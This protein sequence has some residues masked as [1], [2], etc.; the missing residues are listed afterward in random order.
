[1]CTNALDIV[2]CQ[3][4]VTAAMTSHLAA[5]ALKKP[6]TLVIVISPFN[7]DIAKT[8][9]YSLGAD[10]AV[11]TTFLIMTIWSF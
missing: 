11:S 4:K 9:I 8:V 7:D 6:M 1:V 3:V 10:T 2:G 5:P